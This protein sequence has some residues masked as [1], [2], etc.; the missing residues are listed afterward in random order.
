MLC[1]FCPPCERFDSS[2]K[3]AVGNKFVSVAADM[4]Q[5]FKASAISSLVLKLIRH[6]YVSFKIVTDVYTF[7]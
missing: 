7:I 3:C 5:I 1:L 4:G 2:R 6:S